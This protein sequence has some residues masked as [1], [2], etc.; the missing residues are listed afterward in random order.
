[1][2]SPAMIRLGYAGCQACHLSPQGR[3]LLT[4][5]GK[6]IDDTHS[7]RRG[8]YVTDEDRWRRLFH[9]VRLMTQL[10]SEAREQPER[11]TS[12]AARLW[13]RNTTRLSP[14]FRVSGTVSVDVPGR[15]QEVTTLQPLPAAPPVFVRQ[16]L[17]EVTPHKNVYVAIGRDTLPSGVEIA[18]QATYMRSRNVQGFTDVPTQA[19]VFWSTPSFQVAP[20]VFGPSGHEAPGFR[21]SGVGVVA[22]KYLLGDRLAAG[23]ALRAARNRTF[24]ERLVGAYARF[25]LGRWSVLSEHDVVR[26]RERSGDGRHFDQYTG[27]VQIFFFATDWLVASLSADRLQVEDPRHDARWYLRPELSARLTPHITIAVSVRDQYVLPSQRSTAFVLQAF[28]KSV[29]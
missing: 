7:A 14:T 17:F 18:D 15:S 28:V 20:Y 12:A 13:Y 23:L 3:G 8:V 26:R 16:A 27:F 24:D 2:A 4:E 22:E 25:G 9:D 11:V 29:N 1:M 19:K 6:G 21:T 10:S 5:Y